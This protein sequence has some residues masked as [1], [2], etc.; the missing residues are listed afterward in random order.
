MKAR[1]LA[2]V[3]VATLLVVAGGL[4]HAVECPAFVTPLI[5]GQT[6]VVGQVTVWNDGVNL[7]VQYNTNAPWTMSQTHFYA[8]TTMP[9]KFSPGKFPYGDGDLPNVTE[10][11]EAVPLNGWTD[12]TMLYIAT[13]AVVCDSNGG[14]GS[15][16]QGIL[17][18]QALWTD[19]TVP[20]H[21]AD[22]TFSIVGDNLVSDVAALPG[23]GFVA[24]NLYAGTSPGPPV[25]DSSPTVYPP[26]VGTDL[27]YVSWQHIVP[28]ANIN[29]GVG[30]DDTLYLKQRIATWSTLG[31]VC[32][33][34]A[35]AWCEVTIPCEPGDCETAWGLGP[36]NIPKKWGW[37]FD[38][39]VCIP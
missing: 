34:S 23:Y 24:S 39:F 22:V 37:F 7:Y 9:T 19:E 5:G 8:D 30:C 28:L 25:V 11:L 36:Y 32:L 21:V 27:P 16:V 2:V 38:Y 20:Q 6:T 1:T 13:H 4:G 35:F 12:G 17:C 33:P 31:G 29:G 10:Y 26:P 15:S 14:N 3:T 18:V